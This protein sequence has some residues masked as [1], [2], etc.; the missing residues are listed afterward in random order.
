MLLGIIC[1]VWPVCTCSLLGAVDG[2]RSVIAAVVVANALV[3]LV[4]RLKK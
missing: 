4:A 2:I 1:V 3:A